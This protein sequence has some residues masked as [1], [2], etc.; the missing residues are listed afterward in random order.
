MHFCLC[1]AAHPL[2][3][4]QLANHSPVLHLYRMHVTH[5]RSMLVVC[6]LPSRPLS[7]SGV[8]PISIVDT[9]WSPPPCPASN[10]IHLTVARS[11]PA[12]LGQPS[13]V[14][15]LRHGQHAP[16]VVHSHGRYPRHRTAHRGE[17]TPLF[18]LCVFPRCLERD[19][20]IRCSVSSASSPP[21]AR[22]QQ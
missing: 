2:V 18:S 8:A 13:V 19:A 22:P 20:G 12:G 16:R 7:Q 3:G 1:G 4:G 10:P 11:E 21:R 6:R 14:H 5:V 15:T 9:A 17:R